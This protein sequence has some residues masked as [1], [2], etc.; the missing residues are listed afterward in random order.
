MRVRFALY[1]LLFGVVVFVRGV[2][3]LCVVARA[4]WCVFGVLLSRC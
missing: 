2:V 1:E 3:V 4:M